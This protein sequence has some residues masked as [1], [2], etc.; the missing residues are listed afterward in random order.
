M[1]ADATGEYVD[2]VSSAG[3]V[4][5][6]MVSDLLAAEFDRR[7]TLELRVLYVAATRAQSRVVAWWAPTAKNTRL[8][9]LHR[10]LFGR[11]DGQLQPDAKPH[12]RHWSRR[13]SRIRC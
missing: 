7:K 1:S 6:S 3:R 11:T 8:S 10:L 12:Y 2:L 4:Y 5:Q 9:A 13:R